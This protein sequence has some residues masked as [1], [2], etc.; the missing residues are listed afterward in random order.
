[1]QHKDNSF[2]ESVT[3]ADFKEEIFHTKERIN[4]CIRNKDI[5]GALKEY[6][7]YLTLNKL[8]SKKS[9]Q[10]PKKR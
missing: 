10:M 9:S 2:L 3:I 7:A 6:K 5:K 8:L 4:K 1:M